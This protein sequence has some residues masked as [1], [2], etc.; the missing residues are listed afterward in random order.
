METYDDIVLL[1]ANCF[2]ELDPYK[3]YNY[4]GVTCQRCDEQE[5]DE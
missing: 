1:C 2:E 5:N 3:Y 4:D